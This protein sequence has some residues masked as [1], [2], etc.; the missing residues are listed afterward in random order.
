MKPVRI[1]ML[2]L[3]FGLLSNIFPQ[4][5]PPYVEIGKFKDARAFSISP[6]GFI[7]VADEAANEIIKLDTL[8]KIQYTI[9]GYGWS[10]SSFD[11]PSD[12]F[13]S[14]LNV[15]VADKNNDRIQIFDKD[16]NFLSQF[17]TNDRSEEQLFRYPIGVFVSNQ[18]D[19]FILDS[20]NSRLL[21]YNLRGEFLF[22]IGGYDAGSFALNNPTK[23]TIAANQL[24]YVLDSNLLFSYDLFGNGISKIKLQFKPVNINSTFTGI[25]LTDGKN[26]YYSERSNF[27][28]VVDL[29][30]FSANLTNDI[31]DAQ[32]F[33]SKLYV[34]TSTTIFI[35]NL[36]E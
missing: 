25:T 16:L 7:F 17:K 31:R 3:L 36:H 12:I 26:I 32:I 11:N 14:T 13:A 27:R 18:G 5:E 20:D 10:A 4:I 24:I 35:Y 21:K 33:N 8:G 19:L 2:F 29:K 22:T 23:F 15:Y 6:S 28:S 1:Y 30:I 34:L 9:G